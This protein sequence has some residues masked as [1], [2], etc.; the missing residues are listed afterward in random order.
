M[1]PITVR[2]RKCSVP[3][4]SLHPTRPLPTQSRAQT[5]KTNI[6]QPQ[7]NVRASTAGDATSLHLR[8]TTKLFLELTAATATTVGAG[9]AGAVRGGIRVLSWDDRRLPPFPGPWRRRR[10]RRR[11]DKSLQRGITAAPR[12]AR[13]HVQGGGRPRWRDGRGIQE[14]TWRLTY[15]LARSSSS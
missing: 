10:R 1:D 7:K 5:S 15:R 11:R 13:R 12:G 2:E 6:D 8:H 4:P 14:V 3:K 9:A